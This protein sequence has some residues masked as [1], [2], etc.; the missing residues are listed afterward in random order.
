M[1][2][3]IDEIE[4][5]LGVLFR[6]GRAL[7]NELAESVSPGL[8]PSGYGLLVR[9]DEAGPCR[10]SELA[11]YFRIGKATAG[12]QLA[13]LEQLGLV[14]RRPDPEDGR[15]HLLELTDDGRAKVAAARAERRATLHERLSTWPDPDLGALARLLSRFNDEFA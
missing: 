11:A 9:L 1:S 2:E 3:A 15:A 5:Q 12:R 8:E 14:A 13:C 4:Y 10:P 6:R 7:A